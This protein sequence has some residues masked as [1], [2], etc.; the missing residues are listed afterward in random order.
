M[1]T[2]ETPTPPHE[3]TIQSKVPLELSD[4]QLSQLADLIAERLQPP[5]AAGG[6]LVTAAELAERLHVNVKSV[7]R[8]ADELGAVHIGRR[9]MFDP[10]TRLTS[11]C[12]LTPENAVTTP[13]PTPRRRAQKPARCQLL[14]VGRR[15]GT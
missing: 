10:T 12:S 6:G 15:K 8:H 11:V 3:G 13:N 2:Q 4:F 9:V 5:A 1:S 14:P 7:Y